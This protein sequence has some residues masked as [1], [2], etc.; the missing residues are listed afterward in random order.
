[1]TWILAA[2]SISFFVFTILFAYNANNGQHAD[3]RFLFRDPGRTI[4]VLQILTNI[5][6]AS[7]AELAISSHEAVFPF[8]LHR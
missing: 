8:P 2:V 7:I 5:T 6:T 4:L 1:M 3:T